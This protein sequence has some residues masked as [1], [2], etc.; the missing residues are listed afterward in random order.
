MVF[1]ISGYYAPPPP[2]VLVLC[3]FTSTALCLV[4][5]PCEIYNPMKFMNEF[6][7]KNLLLKRL[8]QEVIFEELPLTDI[9]P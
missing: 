1:F 9:K 8:T 4:D 3:T 6:N 2:S 7:S 5:S